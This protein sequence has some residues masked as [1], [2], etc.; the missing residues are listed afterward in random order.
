MIAEVRSTYPSKHAATIA[1][2]QM[3]RIGSPET[4]RH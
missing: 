4:I 3:L 1:V 2:A